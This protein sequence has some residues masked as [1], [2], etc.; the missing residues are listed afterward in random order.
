MR[1]LVKSTVPCGIG[2]LIPVVAVAG[3]RGVCQWY[4]YVV[5]GTVPGTCTPGSTFYVLRSTRVRSTFYMNVLR[6]V[7]TLGYKIQRTVYV[8]TQHEQT[9]I[10]FSKSGCMSSC[11]YVL[12]VPSSFSSSSSV[13]AMPF[14]P[15][16]YNKSKE[17]KW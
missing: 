4:L 14:P 15:Q 11:V 12:R 5:R 9:F 17:T 3:S 13:I 8:H 1:G 7:Y 2:I 10:S 6:T 16:L